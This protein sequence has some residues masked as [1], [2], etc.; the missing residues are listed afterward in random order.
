MHIKHGNIKR[1]IKKEQ[2]NKGNSYIVNTIDR[3]KETMAKH[4]PNIFVIN[5]LNLFKKII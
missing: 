2:W 1:Y 4:K 5:E 3:L